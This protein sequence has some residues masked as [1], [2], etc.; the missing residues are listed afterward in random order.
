MKRVTLYVELAARFSQ[1]VLPAKGCLGGGGV[2]LLTKVVEHSQTTP[3]LIVDRKCVVTRRDLLA[4]VSTMLFT[5]SASQGQ[6]VSDSILSTQSEIALAQVLPPLNFP[7]YLR[8][9]IDYLWRRAQTGKDPGFIYWKKAFILSEAL[10]HFYAIKPVPIAANMV[11]GL[12]NPPPINPAYFGQAYKN[13]SISGIG[14]SPDYYDYKLDGANVTFW[15]DFANPYLGGGVFGRGFVQEEVMFCETPDLANAAAI[16]DANHKAVIH[17]RNPA[18]GAGILQGSPTPVTILGANRVLQIDRS[19]YGKRFETATKMEIVSAVKRLPAAQRFNMLAAAAPDLTIPRKVG[20]SCYIFYRRDTTP[21]V[22]AT[23][24]DLFNTFFAAFALSVDATA[25]AYPA[26]KG[27]ITVNTGKIGCGAFGNNPEVVYVLQRLAA[28]QVSPRLKLKYW[29]YSAAEF[30]RASA[31]FSTICA[32]FN[33]QP[34]KTVNG[35][36][37]VAWRYWGR[38]VEDAFCV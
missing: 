9:E 16:L 30:T 38:K 1:S 3:S 29:D 20:A 25:K 32:N 23:L 11:R 2:K 18:T 21:F 37:D 5:A 19:I 13:F 10:K 24:R 31:A 17:T 27:I 14:Y 33:L 34:N 28:K 15:V 4:G 35:L 7:T 26:Y 6:A 12:P 8:R 36:I 22:K